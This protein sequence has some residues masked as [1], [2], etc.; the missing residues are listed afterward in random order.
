M[1]KSSTIIFLFFTFL[2]PI[3]AQETDIQTEKKPIGIDFFTQIKSVSNLKE[4]DGNIFFVLRQ[5]DKEADRYNSDLYQLIEGKAVR[6][7]STENISDYFFLNDAI[8]FRNIRNK[9]DEEKISNGEALTVFQKLTSGYQEASEWLRLPYAVKDIE[10]INEDHFFFTASYNHQFQTWINENN[11][12]IKEA[13]K[14]KKEENKRYRVF[15]ELP[16]WSNG[17]GD[18]SSTRTHLYYYDKG[19]IKALSDTFETVS[20]L[21]LSPDKK[22]LV[23][24]QKAYR[25]KAP[26]ENQLFSLNI[27]TLERKEWNLFN[28]A[29]YTNAQFINDKEILIVANR[30]IERNRQENA[31][32]YRLNLQSGDVYEVYNGQVYGIGNSIGS[33]IK[34]GGNSK[35][36]FD[37]NGIQYV[38]TVVDQAPLIHLNY[39]DA[40]VSVLTKGNISVQEYLPY[41]DGF[42]AVAM[43][44]QQAGEIYFVDKQGKASALSSIN[45]PLLDKYSVVKPIE[46][47][48]INENG[49]ELNGYVLPPVNYNKNEK[50][51]TILNIHGGPKATYG[52]VFFHEMQYWANQGYAVL[53]T[54]PT[55]SDGR[56]SAFADLRGKYGSVDYNDI[57][58]FVDAAI[59]Q[60]DFIDENRLGVT[61]GSYGGFMTNWIIGHTNRFKA[62]ASQRSIS[63]WL[64][65]SN[66]S[67]IGHIF[68]Q[69]NIGTNAWE[70]SQLLWDQSPLKYADRVKT[71][72][73]FLH[74]DQDYRCWLVEGLQMYYALQY[75]EVP[76]RMVIF[77]NEN[78]ELSRS[79][80]PI[81]RIKRLDEITQ[82]FNKYL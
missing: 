70:N 34:S 33:D 25:G 71:P 45:T 53:F 77:N 42:L 27:E 49:L 62:A 76:T 73:L 11:G 81:N 57:M 60:V 1:K 23:F 36:T 16:F 3:I 10:I 35:I 17:Q 32:F 52:T 48:F 37:K 65:F 64:S 59:E 63:S 55:G 18:V 46:I 13:L 38:S 67:D 19:N 21:E 5:A 4:K 12:D 43:L 31:G 28:K 15:D 58:R 6:L 14:Q 40:K 8:I 20:S 80:R 30:S 51:R 75:F 72:T 68:T 29:S 54:N 41:K 61:G 66:T 56:G 47:K 82:W 9:E 74:S 79:G 69:A 26:L 50:Y 7:T 78:H 24:T 2:F 44:E 22:T 39:K